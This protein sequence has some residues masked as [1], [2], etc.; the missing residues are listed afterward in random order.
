MLSLFFNRLRLP[1]L[2]VLTCCALPVFAE[3]KMAPPQVSL[4]PSGVYLDLDKKSSGLFH[5]TNLGDQPKRVRTRAYNFELDDNS[6]VKLMPPTPQ[7]L[8]QWLIVNPR[9]FTIP[10]KSQQVIRFAVRPPI[11]PEPGEYRAMLYFEEASSVGDAGKG[12]IKLGF[13]LGAPIYVRIGELTEKA[14]LTQ[15]QVTVTGQAIELGLTIHNQGDLSVGLNGQYVL[16][17]DGRYPGRQAEPVDTLAAQEGKSSLV[18]GNLL[19]TPILPGS[20]RTLIQRLPRPSVPGRYLLVLHGT[21][22]TA[23]LHVE[24]PLNIE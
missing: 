17:P 15:H 7:S 23:P 20:L 22:G 11:K 14:S 2:L 9:E 6:Q 19:G 8:D 5:L 1:L 10:P 18:R 3:S 21:L 13:Q 16:W 4:S 12:M 24:L